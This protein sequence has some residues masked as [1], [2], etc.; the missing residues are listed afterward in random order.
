MWCLPTFASD[1]FFLPLGSQDA[2]HLTGLRPEEV[3]ESATSDCLVGRLKAPADAQTPAPVWPS[4]SR[5]GVSQTLRSR[6]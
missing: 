2:P 3:A 4:G 6:L 5:P 1:W